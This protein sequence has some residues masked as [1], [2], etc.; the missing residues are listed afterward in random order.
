MFLS[1]TSNPLILELKFSNSV[2]NHQ[3]NLY[4]FSSISITSFNHN[5]FNY[6]LSVDNSTTSQTKFFIA[7]SSSKP[8]INKPLLK[9]HFNLSDLLLL[10]NNLY[11]PIRTA[12]LQ[13][14]EYYPISESDKKTSSSINSQT[15]TGQNI[16]Q[17]IGYSAT[18][19]SSSSMFVN[20]LMLVEMIFLMKFININY[21]AIVIEMFEKPKAN[22]KLIFQFN[23]IDAPQD[24]NILPSMFSHYKVSVYFLN[25]V[26]EALCQIC[27]ITF[28]ASLFLFITP[29]QR[30]ENKNKK[31]LMKILIFIR[32][33]LVWETS[34]FFILMNLQKIIF[35]VICS[36]TFPP[37]NSINA[38]INLSIATICGFVI[39]LWFIHLA[40]K[41]QVCQ[42]F[43][44][45]NSMKIEKNNELIIQQNKKT[46]SFSTFLESNQPSPSK[47]SSPLEPKNFKKK[48]LQIDIPNENK[49]K[50]YDVLS[51][52]DQSCIEVSDQIK[53]NEDKKGHMT[54]KLKRIFSILFLTKFLF[55]PKNEMIYLRRYELLHK[56]FKFQGVFKKYY[57]FFFYMRQSTLS[58]LAVLFYNYPL[59]QIIIINVVNLVFVI[60]SILSRPFTSYY[61]AMVYII[62]EL[63]IEIALFSGM[64]LAICDFNNDEDY[65]KR[66]QYGWTIILANM[67]LMY[68]VVG[69]GFFK[70]ILYAMH[71]FWKKKKRLNKIQDCQE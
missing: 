37:I 19:I 41:I 15:E 39:V 63:I 7:L 70:P 5:D 18:F 57:V 53:L 8:F 54:Q 49:Q 13:L 35:F 59:F 23:F 38:V 24:S 55:E 4:N 65:R 29:Y 34:L 66:M 42:K 69:T 45:Q 50:T 56:D 40:K 71:E 30:E 26:G 17:G 46:Q 64:M 9:Y 43:K 36:L 12:S 21:P 3:Q 52:N 48:N 20:G 67:I 1:F 61:C 2:L 51:S 58:I 62:S 16:A 10:E 68:W 22:T 6:T 14:M 25:N 33:A 28:V 32:D 27:A 31:I 44:E 47:M 60:Y 11:M